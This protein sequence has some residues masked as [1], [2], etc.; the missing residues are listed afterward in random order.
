MRSAGAADGRLREKSETLSAV[1]ILHPA[2]VRRAAVV[3]RKP[4]GNNNFGDTVDSATLRHT[5]TAEVSVSRWDAALRREPSPDAL[6]MERV[7]IHA[8]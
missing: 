8:R 2:T 7:K 6:S 5:A 3:A 4:K 1:G